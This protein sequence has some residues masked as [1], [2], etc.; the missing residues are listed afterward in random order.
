MLAINIYFKTE[1]GSFFRMDVLPENKMEQ[2][3]YKIQDKG[4]FKPCNVSLYMVDSLCNCLIGIKSLCN[5]S[6]LLLED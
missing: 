2:V 1:N 6:Q 4:G 5:F 3:T